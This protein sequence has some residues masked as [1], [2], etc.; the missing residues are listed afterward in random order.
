MQ[1][2]PGVTLL[3]ATSVDID[4]THAAILR[5]VDQI[6]FGAVK[7]L[8][9]APPTKP[10]PRVQYVDIPPLDFIGY[11]RFIVEQLDAHI[12]TDHCLIVQADGFILDAARW[13]PEFLEYDYIGAPWPEYIAF[14]GGGIGLLRLDRNR[15]G[16]GGFSLRSKRL[17]K[18]TSRLQFDGLD[19][20]IKSEDILICHYL[21]DEM[22]AIGI[23]FAPPEIAALFAIESTRRLYGQSFHA[24]FGFHGKH[25]LDRAVR[26]QDLSEVKEVR[27]NDPCPCGSGKRYKHGHGEFN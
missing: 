4:P 22:C 7:M 9:A 11:S 10:D 3:T 15:V 19:Y 26:A 13:R 25:W 24:V 2:L 20:P 8:S 1:R 12:E 5:C 16:N 17:L 18:A 27:R 23:R 21:Y 14:D 6:K